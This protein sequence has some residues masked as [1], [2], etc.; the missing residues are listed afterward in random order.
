MAPGFA[1]ATAIY[2]GLNLSRYGSFFDRGV[3][4][5]GGAG[6]TLFSAKYLPGNLYT[7]MFM[8]PSVND[9]FPYFHPGFGG[10]ALILTSPAFVLA[11]RPS[12]RRPEPALL[13]IAA[14]IAMTPSL[15]YWTNGFAQYGTRHYLHAFPFLLAMM[16]LG[17]PGGRADQLTKILIVWSVVLVAFGVWHVQL[18]GFG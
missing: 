3:F 13:L 14:L 18:Y 7:L 15:F 2:A 9:K 4:I 1:L 5:F 12:L 10:Q 17:L 8:A 11:L 6:A 16:A